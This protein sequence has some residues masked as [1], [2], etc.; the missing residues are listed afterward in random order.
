[1]K[2]FLSIILALAL[3]IGLVPSVFADGTAQEYSG[4]TVEYD[5]TKF[6]D[7]ADG[8]DVKSAVASYENSYGFWKFSSTGHPNR[9]LTLDAGEDQTTGE[10]SVLFAYCAVGNTIDNEA[11][12]TGSNDKKDFYFTYAID[13]PKTG[14]YDITL[15]NMQRGDK[16]ADAQVFVF[17]ASESFTYSTLIDEWT[18]GTKTHCQGEI[19]S[20]C[21]GERLD[22]TK[23]VG[24]ASENLGSKYFEKGEYIVVFA[25]IDRK[26]ANGATVAALMT[27]IKLTLD[28]TQ[29]DNENYVPMISSITSATDE[30]TGVTTVTATAA[31]MSDGDAATG[32]TYSYAV[33]D[34]DTDKAEIINGNVVKGLADGTATIIATATKNDLSSSKSIEVAVTAP[35]PEKTDLEIAFE[36]DDKNDNYTYTAPSVTGLDFTG[37]VF[38]AEEN[39]NGTY[40]LE[41][42]KADEDGNPFL[43]WAKGLDTKKRII[44]FDRIIEDYIPTEDGKNYLIAVYESDI[45]NAPNEYYNQNGQL[46]GTGTRPALPSMAGYGTADEW[47]Q[48]GTTNIWVAKYGEKTQP[49]NVTVTVN[50]EKRTVPYGK[51]V[52]CEATG[53]NFK[54]WTKQGENETTE[55]VSVDKNYTFKAWENCTV[56]AVYADHTKLSSPMKIFIDSFTAGNETGIMAEFINITGAVEKGIMWNDV[57]IP[58]TNPGNQFTVIA[59]KN[60]TYKGYAILENG[61]GYTLITDGAITINNKAE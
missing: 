23:K 19:F 57:K 21:N 46:I 14:K 61:T 3:I 42:P 56:T 15:E 22:S 27:P 9:P 53:D 59:D 33:A 35:A 44:S 20:Y 51:D 31:K 25:A 26:S 45:E 5:F 13:V 55:I 7:A 50:G 1:M 39:A 43:Y 58:M 48:C 24:S 60:G 52:P 54:C 8:A 34:G 4:I 11:N 18:S 6:V 17:S 49:D 30:E 36:L 2:K 12:K 41:A 37:K 29:G 16:G 10:E 28:G 47:V 40:T 38:T 32:V